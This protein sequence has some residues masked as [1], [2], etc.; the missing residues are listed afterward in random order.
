[1]GCQ[2]R[3]EQ[4]QHALISFSTNSYL[5]LIFYQQHLRDTLMGVQRILG[6]HSGTCQLL[7][8]TALSHV[9]S[10]RT[11]HSAQCMSMTWKVNVSACRR[12][13]ME[14]SIGN[15]YKEQSMYCIYSRIF[16]VIFSGHST[17]EIISK[18]IY[19]KL[20]KKTEKSGSF[21]FLILA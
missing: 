9:R 11:T 3:N 4:P 12:N 5:D 7:H 20:S 19:R 6:E 13:R 15:I 17:S 18:V 16:Y 21:L 14:N 2:R 8:E 1:M 10:V